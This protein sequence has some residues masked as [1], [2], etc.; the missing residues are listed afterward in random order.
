MNLPEGTHLAYT[1]WHEAWYA[2]AVEQAHERPNLMVAASAKGNG[3]GV[4]WEFQVSQYELGGKAVTRVLM[5]D[6][7]YAALVQ[8]P[9]FFAALAEYQPPTLDDVQEILHQFGAVDETE[10]ESPYGPR[11]GTSATYALD[12]VRDGTQ[13]PEGARFR[14]AAITDDSTK[15]D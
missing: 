6:D 7:A 9:E 4:A 3:G 12:E 14:L 15:E 1:V 10:R 13:W 5:F 2:Q 8:V 11:R